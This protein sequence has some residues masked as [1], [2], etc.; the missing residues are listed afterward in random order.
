MIAHVHSIHV[1]TVRHYAIRNISLSFFWSAAASSVC[2]HCGHRLRVLP[3]LL[4][5][6]ARGQL[7]STTGGHSTGAAWQPTC[8]AGS[9]SEAQERQTGSGWLAN[10][11]AAA[12]LSEDRWL[13]TSQPWMPAS[14]LSSVDASDSGYHVV[15]GRPG[16]ARAGQ[17]GLKLLRPGLTDR[18]VGRRVGRDYWRHHRPTWR[19]NAR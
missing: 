17:A 8:A 14:S 3:D 18:Q 1:E 12:Q 4:T 13:F 11:T 16:G 9:V 15:T 5:E 19:P 7:T 6:P 10:S 2:L